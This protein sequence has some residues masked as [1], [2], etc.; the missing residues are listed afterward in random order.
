MLDICNNISSSG[1]IQPKKK[2]IIQAWK[3]QRKLVRGDKNFELLSS[4]MIGVLLEKTGYFK[5]GREYLL[6]HK[7]S[8]RQKGLPLGNFALK[9]YKI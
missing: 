6:K 4:R 8:V 1:M 2:K 9:K 3:G 5:H 7:A